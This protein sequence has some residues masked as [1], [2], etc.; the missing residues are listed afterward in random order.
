MTMK[1]RAS[2]L[3]LCVFG[4]AACNSP[5]AVPSIHPTGST[6][7]VLPHESTTSSSQTVWVANLNDKLPGYNS[8]SS[9]AYLITGSN[10][11]LFESINVAADN[12]TGQIYVANSIENSTNV[13]IVIF[14]KDANGN[15]TPK[16][17]IR[18]EDPPFA[19]YIKIALD[20]SQNLWVGNTAYPTGI[21]YLLEFVPGQHGLTAPYAIIEG[22]NT[23][24]NDIEGVAT[25]SSGNV[26]VSDI[27]ALQIDEFPR[28][29]GNISPTRTISGS[30]TGL[31][32][33]LGIA[34]DGNGYIYVADYLK[35]N[36]KIFGPSQSGN[37]YPHAVIDS[38]TSTGL[39]EPVSVAID[40]QNNIWVGDGGAQ[41]VFEFSA[42]SSGT[43]PPIREIT[44]GINYPYG[45]AICEESPP[46]ES[47]GSHDVFPR[48]RI[49]PK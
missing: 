31:E 7:S 28:S 8:S 36:V 45:I 24:L 2:S 17:Y 27:G 43:T 15:A 44:N 21:A 49:R 23:T 39:E 4:I 37:V 3:V 20:P 35:G 29:N 10:T 9:P 22:S 1:F 34:V 18:S 6:S 48:Q 16:H 14:G 47:T 19:D 46:C 38:G 26:Y 41:A 40:A 30:H 12:T 5:Q 13:P 42:G 33:P 11:E 32:G 25:D